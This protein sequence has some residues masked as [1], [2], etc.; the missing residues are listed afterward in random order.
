MVLELNL[1]T[2]GALG[3]GNTAPAVDANDVGLL[4][5]AR[6]LGHSTEE[7]L[8]LLLLLGGRGLK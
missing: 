3:L 1:D 2:L 7:T 5:A 6:T 4:V 8:L